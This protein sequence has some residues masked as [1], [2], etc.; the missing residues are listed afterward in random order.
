MTE[1]P[2]FP[3]PGSSYRG[4]DPI[5][6]RL[7]AE[8]PVVR[9]EWT[10]GGHAWLVT[11]YA[12]VRAVLEDTRFSR[13]ASYAPDAP[14]FSGLFQAPP[15]MIISLDP[16]DHTRLRVLATQAFS[17][18]RIEGMRPRMRELAGRL[19]D[20]LEKEAADGAAV[21]LVAGFASPLAMSVICELLG[22]P[23][24]DREQFHT[25][26]RQFAD[27]SGPEEQAVEGREKLGA[28]IAGLVG[29]KFEGPGDD[30][31]SALIQARDG[32]DRLSFEELIGLGYTLLGGGFDSAAGQIS[33]FVLT[34]LAHHPEVWRRLGDHPEE[35]PAAV[36]ELLRTV[37]LTGNDTSGLPRI[38]TEDVTLGGV[39]IPAGDAVFLSFA[40]ANRDEA[41]FPDA[42]RVDF[43]RAADPH[44]AFG[45]GIHHC[46]GAPLARIE[47]AV[48]IEELT[49]RFPAARPAV[50]EGELR[51][52]IGDVNHNLVALPLRL[53]D[54]E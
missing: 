13:A 26:V 23:E 29:S 53:S 41:V 18:E 7:R 37:N 54:G 31:L 15:G 25:W 38:A 51:W 32:E 40:S 4:P 44:L 43:A 50:A 48:A 3:F 10:G 8:R 34:L 5:F 19:L 20:S 33:N 46:L 9:V 22:V 49:R 24:Q 36:E 17:P 30:V 14:K 52:R 1:L 6:T 27:V 35:I 16:P 2:V 12:D 21:D 42:D 39:T 45:H 47:L 28:Y 11:R